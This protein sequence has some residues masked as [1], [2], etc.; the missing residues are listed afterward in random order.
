VVR[1]YGQAVD[2][3]TSVFLSVKM[4]ELE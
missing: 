1:R 4:L 3:L 2:C